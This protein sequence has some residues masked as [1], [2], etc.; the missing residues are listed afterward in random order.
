M[1]A[2]GTSREGYGLY[3]LDAQSLLVDSCA[4][5]RLSDLIPAMSCGK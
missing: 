2:F 5:C 3:P 1:T 4:P